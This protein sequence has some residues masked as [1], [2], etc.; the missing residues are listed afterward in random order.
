MI[1]R[2]NAAV[3]IFA[4]AAF[5]ASFVPSSH[6]YVDGFVPGESTVYSD[7]NGT[8]NPYPA[9][10]VTSPIF[11]T[12]H[13]PA[14][15]DD[16]LFQNLLSAEW[17]VYNFY[18]QGVEAFTAS[19]FTDKGYKSNTYE[20][21]TEIRDNEAGHLAI[22]IEVI[23]PT[24]LK[25][26]PCKYTYPFDNDVDVYLAFQAVF[27]ST[28]MA[29]LTALSLQAKLNATKGTLVA[30]AE[31]EARHLTWAL[32]DVWGLNPFAG[33]VDTV[34][35]YVNQILEVTR[36]FVIP[37]SCPKENPEYPYP[38]Q[39]LPQLE[40]PGTAV[41][42]GDKL[43]F[44]YSNS[45]RVP[46]FEENRKYYAVFFHGVL[47]ISVPFDVKTSS[48]VIPKFENNGIIMVVIAD[49]KGAPTEDSVLAGPLIID[50]QPLIVP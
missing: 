50:L 20:R 17:I 13:G 36:Q 47:E 12:Q 27:E 16:L 46:S 44:T 6:A 7:Y 8:A 28:S 9:S 22:F 29:F 23:S 32:I 25:P 34:Y 45:S 43:T 18:Q 48:S 42:P 4:F 35:P 31:V 10:N 26:G 49:C 11:P 30:I 38:R 19:N 39:G 5:V 21:I 3:T 1:S 40:S 24:S 33:P 41:V 15:A 37:G 2:G 14:G